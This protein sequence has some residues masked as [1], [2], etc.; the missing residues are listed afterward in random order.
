MAV[1]VKPVVVELGPHVSDPAVHHVAGG[2]HVGAG[3]GLRDRRAREQLER[4][5][6]VDRAVGAQQAAVAVGGVLAQAH[7][8]DDQRVRARV[9]DRAGGELHDA[10][11]VPGA[12]AL[13]VLVGGQAEQQ[14]AGDAAVVQRPRLLSGGAD[15]Q[16]VDAGH[17]VDGRARRVLGQGHEQGLDQVPRR[18]VGLAHEVAE[19]A[20][21]P[22]PAQAGLGERH[23][24]AQ[25]RPAGHSS[26]APARTQERGLQ[27]TRAT[28]DAA[29]ASSMA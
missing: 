27:R 5:V 12:A 17:G 28:E 4:R 25:D 20:G 18:E 10:L 24:T 26:A 6:V 23:A 8:G 15:R 22:Q 13:L 21:A 9:L 29:G 2:D 19:R 14:H 1:S 3:A 16:A 11:V 7:V